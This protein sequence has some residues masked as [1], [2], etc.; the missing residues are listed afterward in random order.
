MENNLAG[1]TACSRGKIDKSFSP[2]LTD[3]FIQGVRNNNY[4]PATKWSITKSGTNQW[5]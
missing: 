3:Y 5:N 4:I 1:K 2:K